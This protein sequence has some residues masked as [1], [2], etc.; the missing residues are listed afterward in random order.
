[1]IT[2]QTQVEDLI[3]QHPDAIGFLMDRG[4]V[5]LVC[6]EPFWG[7]LGELLAQKRVA[8]PE[9]VLA[10]LRA[11]LDEKEGEASRDALAPR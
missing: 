7:A 2:A 8:D 5:C 9:A 6:G 10:D 4:V 1:M 3:A 11:F